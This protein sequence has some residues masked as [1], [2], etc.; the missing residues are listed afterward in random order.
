MQKRPIMPPTLL[1]SS[2]E[3]YIH[4]MGSLHL[5]CLTRMSNSPCPFLEDNVEEEM[6]KLGLQHF[7]SSSN[8]LVNKSGKHELGELAEVFGW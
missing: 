3:R 1:S 4:F 6:H 8:K 7:I 5:L 2:S